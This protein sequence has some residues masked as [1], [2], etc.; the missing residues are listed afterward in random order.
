M[1]QIEKV[2]R[3]VRII[4]W[5]ALAGLAVAIPLHLRSQAQEAK[6]LT[7]EAT[8]AAA[9]AKA[10]LAKKEKEEAEKPL[11]LPA[12]SMGQSLRML[13]NAVGVLWFSNASPRAGV[14]C[15]VGT[16]SKGDKQTQSLPA[17]QKVGP[18]DTNVKVAM[19][20][21]GASIHD[22][23]PNDDC[24]FMIEDAPVQAHDAP[25]AAAK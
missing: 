25:V 23:C 8:A 11:R 7:D 15:V 12:A 1:A 22:I 14:V 13:D 21:A 18:Y 24:K 4:L 3:V 5:L 9:K 6:R 16:A 17:C 20:F 10:E 19:M 2:E